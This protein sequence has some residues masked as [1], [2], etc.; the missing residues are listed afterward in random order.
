MWKTWPWVAKIM[1]KKKKLYDRHYYLTLRLSLKLQKLR[2]CKHIK[3]WNIIGSPE[4]EPQ[5]HSQLV[6]DK[7]AKAIQCRNDIF[8]YIWC[9]DNYMYKWKKNEYRPR[10]IIFMEIK[11]KWVIDLNVKHRT[12]KFLDENIQMT[13]GLPMV[14]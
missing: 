1:L 13:L 12:I 9:W 11:S 5:K 8:S 3:P 14:F 7:R 4:V 6:F 10:F 2:E